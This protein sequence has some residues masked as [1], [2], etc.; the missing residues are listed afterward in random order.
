MS[1]AKKLPS[2]QEDFSAWYHEV[3]IQGQLVDASPTR[4]CAVLR[5]YGYGIWEQIQ[6]HMDVRLK[7]CGVENAYF[8]LLIPESFITKE[9][10]HVDGFAPELAVVTHAGG[11][12]LEEPYVVRPTS[13]TMIYHMFSRW[14]KSWRDLPL[15]INQW[16]NV[17]RWEMRTRPFLRTTEFLWQEA[18]TAHATKEEA[19][20]TAREMLHLSVDMIQ[21]E[22]CIPLF[23]GV[24]TAKERF[25]GA[26]QTYCME[27]IMPDGKA[28]QI[29]T[30]H[31]L[32]HSF[33]AAYGVQFQNKE[34][35]MESPWCTS[36]GTTTRMVGAVIMEH[37]DDNGLVL[38]PSVAPYQV[39]IVPIY[40]KDDEKEQVLAAAEKYADALRDV[41]VRVHVDARDERPGAK[42]FAWELRG[43]P[44]RIEL[45]PRDI[46]N[47][48]MMV[49]TRVQLPG[50]D[51]KSVIEAEDV[52]DY[53]LAL[54]TDVQEYLRE[55]AQQ[56]VTSLEL[57]ERQLSE[58]GPKM[59]DGAGYVRTGWC[60]D[61]ACEE[62]LVKYKAGIRC[63]LDEKLTPDAGCFS[64]NES[65]QSCVLIA[66]GY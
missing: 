22:L 51:G 9:A 2:M 25:A 14:I 10:E 35:Q 20:A 30:S 18:H 12:K 5:P 26:E 66:K 16:A 45:G 36:L 29:G 41:G 58:F 27:A 64:C 57:T 4:G 8:P 1:K 54:V 46:A 13:E 40:R 15:K 43:A 32:T 47:S 61:T 52:T 21:D 31:L 59:A 24:K 49:A 23:T 44:V 42:F 6:K 56:M 37:G 28:L 3:I 39:V 17:V 7:K 53:I 11:K 34:G 50:R 55:R 62:K 48:S 65:A 19:D 33:P 63:I 38:P 60:G